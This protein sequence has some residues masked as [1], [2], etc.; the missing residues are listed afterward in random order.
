M[1]II[2]KNTNR[3][4]N[5]LIFNFT[6]NRTKIGQQ[7]HCTTD[8]RYSVSIMLCLYLYTNTIFKYRMV[9]HHPSL[10]TRVGTYVQRGSTFCF[11]VLVVVV[12]ET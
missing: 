11:V 6:L 3:F 4:L 7:I 2:I 1:S 9:N 5:N 8:I 12:V 10:F